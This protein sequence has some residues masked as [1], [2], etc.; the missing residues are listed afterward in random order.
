MSTTSTG[1]D[2]HRR[3]PPLL[4]RLRSRVR[5]L[6]R[7][8]AARLRHPLRV[9]GPAAHLAA[10][11]AVAGGRPGL[12]H[13]HDERADGR[14]GPPGPRHRPVGRDGAAGAGQGGT[15]RRR[16]RGRSRPTPASRRSSRGPS[17]SSSPGTSC[18]RCPT[19]P[20]RCA[21]G[22]RCCGPA[23]GWCW[24]RDAGAWRRPT[25]SRTCRG[26]PACPPTSWRRVVGEL[27][28][29]PVVVQLTDTRLLGQ[30]RSSTSATCCAR[31]A[32]TGL[33]P[34]QPLRRRR[35]PSPRRPRP[36]AR[37]GSSRHGGGLGARGAGGAH[38]AVDGIPV[39]GAAA[40]RHRRRTS[41]SPGVA[42]TSPCCC[43]SR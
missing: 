28:G 30:A 21:A 18:G 4:G 39:R 27:V 20:R 36:D 38:G 26:A 6:S 25:A 24:S 3:D 43:C 11:D 16:D 10:D 33:R 29:E 15:V 7:P 5:Q 14:D 31:M 17:T 37:P 19:P 13:R 32:P 2:E 22:P 12:R 42:S 8:R 41:T 35:A 40:A 9:E 34:R 23:A 1:A